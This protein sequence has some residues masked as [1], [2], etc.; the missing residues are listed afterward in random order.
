MI[1]NEFE[2][3]VKGFL[4]VVISLE[5][6]FGVNLRSLELLELLLVLL[7]TID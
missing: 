4:G 7:I 5:R 3:V 6:D 1:S 2:F